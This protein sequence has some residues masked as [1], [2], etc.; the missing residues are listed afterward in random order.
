MSIAR[1]GYGFV[2]LGKYSNLQKN[3]RLLV[4]NL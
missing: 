2:G 1:S 3:P 4:G